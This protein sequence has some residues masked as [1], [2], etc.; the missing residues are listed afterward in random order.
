MKANHKQIAEHVGFRHSSYRYYDPS[1][2]GLDIEGMIQ[3]L[4][5]C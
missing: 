2:R 1:T 5:V 4:S 3:D